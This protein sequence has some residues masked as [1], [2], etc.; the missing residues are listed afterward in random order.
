MDITMGRL[1]G[2]R[3]SVST[4]MVIVTPIAL[5]LLC[6]VEPGPVV[7]VGVTVLLLLGYALD[8]AD[9]QVAR[10]SG[11]SGPA[12]EWLD[13]VTDQARTV[14][15]HMAVLIW[16]YRRLTGEGS[17]FVDIGP[18][19]AHGAGAVEMQFQTRRAPVRNGQ[20]DRHQLFV[21]RVDGSRRVRLLHELPESPQRPFAGERRGGFGRRRRC[22]PFREMI[23]ACGPGFP[24]GRAGLPGGR[25]RHG[26]RL[27]RRCR[28]D[29]VRQPG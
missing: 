16:L 28:A 27:E 4:E 6:L 12:G 10:L 11:R 29:Q 23:A 13:H 3:G 19:D 2:D 24:F 1:H 5:A 26:G 20:D 14:S 15:L 18:R 22:F 17:R 25:R 21:T 9:G 8:S 7:A